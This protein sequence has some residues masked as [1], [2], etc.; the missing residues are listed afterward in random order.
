MKKML[1]LIL[2]ALFLSAGVNYSFAQVKEIK[3]LSKEQLSKIEQE[4]KQLNEFK[5]ELDK[6]LTQV[7][8][9]KDSQLQQDPLPKGFNQAQEIFF[10]Q[11]F[12]LQEI[13]PIFKD[14]PLAASFF[15]LKLDR[16]YVFSRLPFDKSFLWENFL[17][18]YAYK[19]TFELVKTQEGPYLLTKVEPI[20]SKEPT[21][22]YAYMEFTNKYN[23]IFFSGYAQAMDPTDSGGFSFEILK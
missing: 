6:T 4:N 1:Y 12:N 17:G 8:T 13:V 22:P 20:E 2:P 7:K 15:K 5:K 19:F 23:A 9:Q 11:R 14:K 10:G 16:D 18:K 3:E 21:V